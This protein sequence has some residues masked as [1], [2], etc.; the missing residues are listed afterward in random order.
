MPRTQVVSRSGAA[1]QH[2]Y[3]GARRRFHRLALLGSI[4]DPLPGL[5][6]LQ[7]RLHIASL[8]GVFLTHLQYTA[9]DKHFILVQSRQ[10][11]GPHVGHGFLYQLACLRQRIDGP[12]H[13]LLRQIQHGGSGRRQLGP[14]E[15]SWP[16]P[17][18]C[19][20]V[21]STAASTRAPLSAS[22]PPERAI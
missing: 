3:A 10:I 21:N 11:T 18:L 14:R 5:D 22:A 13:T 19:R 9:A 12:L 4:D 8:I 16:F 1:R 6:L 7:N 17:Q 20:K 15:N 2:K